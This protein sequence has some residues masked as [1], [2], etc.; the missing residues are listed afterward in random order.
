[1]VRDYQRLVET[2]CPEDRQSIRTHSL[3]FCNVFS[4]TAILE[5][6]LEIESYFIQ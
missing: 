4:L 5:F 2:Y 3:F 1:M 6:S